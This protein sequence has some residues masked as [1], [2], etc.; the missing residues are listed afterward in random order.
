[1]SESS[2]AEGYAVGQGNNANG[3]LGGY[4][5]EWIWIIILFAFWG[6]GG[7]EYGQQ[8]HLL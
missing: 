5:W 3:G 7:S 6:N 1:M 8:L 4:G 2:F